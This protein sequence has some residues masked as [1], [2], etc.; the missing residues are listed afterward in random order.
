[1]SLHIYILFKSLCQNDKNKNKN[2][3]SV[4]LMSARTGE[5][6][7]EVLQAILDYREK[8][9]ENGAITEKRL[10]QRKHWMW[11]NLIR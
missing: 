3:R 6:L 9:S 4:L 5:G 8:M 1:M 2:L 10:V 7:D 11:K